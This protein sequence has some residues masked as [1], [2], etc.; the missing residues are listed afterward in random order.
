MNEEAGPMSSTDDYRLA[1]LGRVTAGSRALFDTFVLH[2]DYM[3]R[4][5][6]DLLQRAEQISFPVPPVLPSVEAESDPIE[7]DVV[8]PAVVVLADAAASSTRGAVPPRPPHPVARSESAV[9]LRRGRVAPLVVVIG[10]VDRLGEIEDLTIELESFPELD[11]HFRLFRAGAYRV[12]ASCSDIDALVGRLRVR[13]DV[14]AV[15]RQ[16]AAV[17]VLPAPPTF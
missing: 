10:P 1:R 13:K 11:V 6:S 9:P 3:I 4:F 2:A 17:H 7:V 8:A 14:L 5:T 12:D 16:G 15:E